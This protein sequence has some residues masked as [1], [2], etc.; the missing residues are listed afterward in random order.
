MKSGGTELNTSRELSQ[1]KDCLCV[2]CTAVTGS[3]VTEGVACLP[4]D[5]VVFVDDA[6]QGAVF[7][8]EAVTDHHAGSAVE[9]VEE[10]R[11]TVNTFQLELRS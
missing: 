2:T 3:V 6:S 9:A 5:H 4:N 11:Q 1:D 8:G 10:K 7:N